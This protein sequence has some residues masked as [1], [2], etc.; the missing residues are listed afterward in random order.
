MSTNNA[1]LL[2][3]YLTTSSALSLSFV[4]EFLFSKSI[5]KSYNKNTQTLGEQKKQQKQINLLKQKSSDNKNK[6][7]DLTNK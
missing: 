5:H 1:C 7:N 4:V 6:Y 3:R 2:D